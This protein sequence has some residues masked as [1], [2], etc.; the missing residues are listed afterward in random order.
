MTRTEAI[1][2]FLHNKGFMAQLYT[3]DMEV[4]VNVAKLDGEPITGT[5]AGKRWQ[6]FS[7][8]LNT[9][10]S[11]RIPWNAATN[12]YYEDK[13]ITFDLGRYVEAIGMTG[14]DWKNKRSLWVGFDFDSLVGHKQGLTND[15]LEEIKRT[16]AKI[17]YITL[18]YSTGG[19]G[20]HPYV[21]CNIPG[22]TT[23]TEHAAVARAILGKICIQSGLNLEAKVDTLGGNMWVYHT[24]M[25]GQGFKL[26]KEGEIY[27]DVLQWKNYIDRVSPGRLIPK[28]T[29][30]KGQLLAAKNTI[31]LDDTHRKLLAWFE[32][33]NCL[34][35]WDDDR[36]MLVCHTFD[37]KRA[38][39]ELELAGIFETISTGGT[40]NDQNCFC[41]PESRGTWVCRRH[42]R[43]VREH[44]LWFTDQ[45][46]WT[47]CYYNK[48]PSFRAASEQVGGIEGE[49]EYNY[50]SLGLAA[51]ALVL[52]GC[53]IDIPETC[54]HRPATVR[55][56]GNKFLVSFNAEEG[57]Q[58]EG[59]NKK[60]KRWQ[61]IYSYQG[62][63][64]EIQLPD[65]LV[66][67]VVADSTDLGWF[68]FT[69]NSWVAENKS[70]AVSSLLTLGHKRGYIDFILGKC[71]VNNWLL[72]V[73]PFEPEYPGNR[74]W[75][76]K[77]PQFRFNC[78]QG[79]HPTWDLIFKHCGADLEPK[80]NKWCYDNGIHDGFIYL[81][82][83]VAAFFQYP[84]EPTPYLV[85]YGE[86]NTGKSIFH[87]SLSLLFTGGYIRADHALT[88]PS[89]FNGEL[90]NAVLCVV[91]ETDLAR[92]GYAGDRIKD[93]V[94]GRQISVH[95][96]GRTPFNIRN[97]THWVQCTNDISYCPILPGDTRIVLAKV[98]SLDDEIPKPELIE[99]CER[100]APG[101]L[102]TIMQIEI[103]PSNSRLR[104]PVLDGEIKFQQQELKTSDLAAFIDGNILQID[105]AKILFSTFSKLFI[106][107]LDPIEK[108][109]WTKRR[110]SKELLSLGFSKGRAGADGNIYVGN[111]SLERIDPTA[112]LKMARG[113]L[114]E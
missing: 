65:E 86:Q 44:A 42:T 19:V 14:W 38:H 94:T 97:C 57:D 33:S 40:D 48:R 84:T 90:E 107:W 85:F 25:V 7:D 79:K 59:W 80:E 37:L 24:R 64:D 1:K 12:P 3:P 110:I 95:S 18:C 9:W 35:W 109:D 58:I 49:K 51:S 26:I 61:K 45:S 68:I 93:W 102:N 46:G 50:R 66:R 77:A 91:E 72:E 83:W 108:G 47:T 71:I 104:V 76:R 29:S 43:G 56:D 30:S 41:F 11:F 10:K 20:L 98:K 112:R 103:P 39:T 5:Y 22:V 87:E 53:D 4:Q 8:G 36:E 28:T 74:K 69:N 62:G 96:K 78:K 114:C 31:S 75:N 101:F 52:A 15:E 17:P 2:K 106:D 21:R 60:S 70:N 6:G 73:R 67:H 113:R 100:E 55:K 92:K 63:T 88:N 23:H 32:R 82:Y 99:R 27:D 111:V 13:D 105:G 54:A 34:S 89:G 16:L 81:Q